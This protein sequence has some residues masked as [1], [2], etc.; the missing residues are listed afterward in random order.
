MFELAYQPKWDIRWTLPRDL[1]QIEELYSGY[2]PWSRGEFEEIQ[3]HKKGMSI[4]LEEG[5]EIIGEASYLLTDSRVYVRFLRAK[6][7]KQYGYLLRYLLVSPVVYAKNRDVI[8]SVWERDNQLLEILGACSF[9]VFRVKSAEL[10]GFYSDDLM[11]EMLW[12]NRK[13]KS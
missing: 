7:T 3:R 9:D 1:D 6:T 5:D 8:V 2:V 12:K 10:G 4:T 11:I 13:E